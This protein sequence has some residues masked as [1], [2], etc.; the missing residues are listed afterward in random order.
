MINYVS[1]EVPG[2]PRCCCCRSDSRCRHIWR[3]S[4][5][6]AADRSSP[7]RRADGKTRLR[8]FRTS[9]SSP[10]TNI[11]TSVIRI[12][13]VMEVML[14]NVVSLQLRVF[15]PRGHCLR[16]RVLYVSFNFVVSPPR[17]QVIET[18]RVYTWPL[19]QVSCCHR[20]NVT[21]FKSDFEETSA[22]A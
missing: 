10:L 4:E 21:R 16:R 5:L 14:L 13:T 20:V 11:K 17:N 2:Q 6:S 1:V 12:L 22:N 9:V 18:L 19:R 8:T 3:K 15:L 7:V